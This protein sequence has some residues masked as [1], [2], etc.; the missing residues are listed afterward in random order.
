MVTFA[1]PSHVR[2]AVDMPSSPTTVRT[3]DSHPMNVSWVAKSNTGGGFGLTFCPGKTA[4][5][6]NIRWCRSLDADLDRLKTHFG[7]TTILCLLSQAELNSLRL[8]HYTEAVQKK[9]IQ[10]LMFPIVEMAAPD[11]LNK[12]AA[13][14]ELIQEKYA[15]MNGLR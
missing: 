10:L 5:R 11:S 6:G 7:V 13:I 15:S 9:G 8:R 4:S 12:T 1:H 14:I 3:S 2:R